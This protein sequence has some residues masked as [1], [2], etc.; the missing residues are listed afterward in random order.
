VE[1]VQELP[2]IE[3][4]TLAVLVSFS[5]W[6]W[7]QETSVM[8]IYVAPVTDVV[9]KRERILNWI[10]PDDFRQRHRIISANRVKGTGEWFLN[11]GKY[12]TWI[13]GT[14]S[15]LLFCHGSCKSRQNLRR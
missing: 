11:M 1:V 6:Q 2:P 8:V 9:E 7:F 14:T 4:G 5:L 15:N 12:K 10:F 3:P 13:K